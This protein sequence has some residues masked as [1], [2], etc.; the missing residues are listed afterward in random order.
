MIS[1]RELK[2]ECLRRKYLE[3]LER[4]DT[5][6]SASNWAYIISERM[7]GLGPAL[8]RKY[9]V[10]LMLEPDQR[11]VFHTAALRHFPEYLKAVDRQHAVDTVYG[12]YQTSPE[13]F[14]SLVDQC[15]LFDAARIREIVAAGTP[16]ALH[17][18][19]RVL[20][21]F[22]PGYDP[23]D[24]MLMRRLRE[25]LRALPPLGSIE[26]RRGL[27]AYSRKYVC[28]RG[29]VNDAAEM[30]CCED[31]CGLDIRGLSRED[32]DAVEQYDRTVDILAEMIQAYQTS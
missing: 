9:L 14:V 25:S 24:L 13:A 2:A 10:A 20:G 12:D 5:F 7:T 17:V 15:Q 31:G 1:A 32:E 28:P 19:A 18:A 21:A 26:E 30:Y 23:A 3:L 27:I 4:P 11:S 6:P 16:E 8:Y 29:H 22:Q